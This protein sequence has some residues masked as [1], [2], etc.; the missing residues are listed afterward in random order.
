VINAQITSSKIVSKK[1]YEDQTQTS[2]LVLSGHFPSHL[3]DGLTQHIESHPDITKFSFYDINN[4]N[5]IMFTADESIDLHLINDL[6]NDFIRQFEDFD[7]SHDLQNTAYFE[8][9]KAVK[10]FV[11]GIENDE[12][13]NQIIN[14]LLIEEIIISAEINDEN[15]CKITMS[16]VIS[17]E[18][19]RNIF[20]SYGLSI[21]EIQNH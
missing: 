19:I 6:I 17:G 7:I 8:N 1:S 13:K 21:T 12:H 14:N 15:I 16:K 18:L 3:I 5:K 9:N 4:I 20:E 2:Y 11:G 10:F